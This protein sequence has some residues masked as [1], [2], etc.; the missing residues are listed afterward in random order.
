MLI[1]LTYTICNYNALM[2]QYWYVILWRIQ[3]LENVCCPIIFVYPY[4]WHWYDLFRLFLAVTT[5]Y[6]EQ[7]KT[8]K[9]KF[10]FSKPDQNWFFFKKFVTW[11]LA[12]NELVPKVLEQKLLFLTE[13]ISTTLYSQTNDK[14][15]M[16]VTKIDK[17]EKYQWP[18]TKDWNFSKN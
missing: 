3:N 1:G 16:L 4:S 10:N 9:S 5:F 14:R 13:I 7:W 12:K 8:G 2:R 11:F 17:R 15:K 6:C 18:E